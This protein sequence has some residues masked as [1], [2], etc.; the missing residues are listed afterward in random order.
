MANAA[1]KLALSMC[2]RVSRKLN[3]LSLSFFDRKKSGE[4]LSRVT[5]DLD[6]ISETLQISLLKFISVVG[7]IIGSVIMMFY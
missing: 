5:N 6:K 1:E 2:V 4:I 7:T 3:V